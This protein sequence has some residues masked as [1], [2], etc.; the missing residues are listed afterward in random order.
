ML[1]KNVACKWRLCTVDRSVQ[2][3]TRE[4][5]TSSDFQAKRA[6]N[7]L[8]LDKTLSRQQNPLSLVIKYFGVN[9]K[10]ATHLLTIQSHYKK[11]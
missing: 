2:I 1:K 6:Q 3:P 8:R 5:D 11:V 10:A 9:Y 4:I 7:N